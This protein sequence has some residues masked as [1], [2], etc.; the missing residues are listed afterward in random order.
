MILVNICSANF[1]NYP[2]VGPESG[3]R[4]L[5][6]PVRIRNAGFFNHIMF[7]TLYSEKTG[8]LKNSQSLLN[9]LNP[10]RMKTRGFN[11]PFYVRFF[12]HKTDR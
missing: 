11:N 2:L 1:M 9:P 3:I 4:A 12:L 6:G 7:S 10:A 5:I 8:P